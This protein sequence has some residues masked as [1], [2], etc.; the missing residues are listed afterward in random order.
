MISDF[1]LAWTYGILD[2]RAPYVVRYTHSNVRVRFFLRRDLRLAGGSVDTLS[3]GQLAEFARR[4]PGVRS[5]DVW[6]V[7]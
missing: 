6:R 4:W 7:S 3:R 1:H 5:V 2:P